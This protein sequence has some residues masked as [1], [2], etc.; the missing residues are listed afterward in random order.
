VKPPVSRIGMLLQVK[1]EKLVVTSEVLVVH[2]MSS[3]KRYRT[4]PS[5]GELA[6]AYS[7]LGMRPAR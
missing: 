4:T 2:G 5:S 7:F 1:G 3:L 6:V